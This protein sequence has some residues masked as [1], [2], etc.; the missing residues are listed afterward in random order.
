M[1][2]TLLVGLG[3]GAAAALLFASV[4]SGILLAVL[5]FYL[6]PLP[7]MIAALGWSHWAGL[8]AAVTAAA[9][10]GAAFGGVLAMAFLAAVAVP[11]WWL[12]YLALLGR[13][14]EVDGK[15]EWYPPGRLVLWAAAMGAL[16]IALALVSYGTDEAAIRAGLRTALAR[17]LNQPTEIAPDGLLHLPGIEDS[18]RLIDLFV[19]VLPPMAAFIATLTELFNLWLAGHAVKLSGRLRRP[20]PNHGDMAF[21]TLSVA[22]LAAAFAGAFLPGLP[23][24][25]ARLFVATLALAFTIVGFVFLH[26]ATRGMTGRAALLT[27]AYGVVVILGWPALIVALLGVVDTLFRWR[28]RTGNP[29]AV[30]GS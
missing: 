10:L 5:L 1:M 20:W 15:L 14:N 17:M 3:A 8:V 21:S 12:S 28:A 25:I 7:L 2:Q 13:P 6:A 22:A 19:F 23:G 4:S 30:N 9:L 11:A 24:M 18:D 27:G 29:P 26:A 16:V